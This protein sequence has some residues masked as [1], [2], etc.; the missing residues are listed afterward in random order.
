M[1]YKI[2]I[3]LLCA[4]SINAS[5]I[6]NSIVP[7]LEKFEFPQNLPAKKYSNNQY[8]DIRQALNRKEERI[9]IVSYQI[10]Y[11]NEKAYQSWQWRV[12]RL[13]QI[14]LN[15]NP[16]IFCLQ[17]INNDQLRNLSLLFQD[18]HYFG[19]VGNVNEINAIFV[20]KERF[21]MQ[22]QE[23]CPLQGRIKATFIQL[24]D[25]K[26]QHSFAVIN[27]RLTYDQPD[28]REKEI[29]A[30]NEFIAPI[31]EKMP[32][33]LAG[34]F[35]TYAPRLD[36]DYIPFHDGNYIQR[37]LNKSSLKNSLKKAVLGHMGPL[38]STISS[39]GTPYVY[40]DQIFVSENIDVLLH[41]VEPATVDGFY[42]SD[43]MPVI[44][45]LILNEEMQ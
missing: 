28:Q 7:K 12:N 18:Y 43:H 11:K 22:Q 21:T 23:I 34:A 26:T 3:F 20:R 33:I 9:R 29:L 5:E 8:M 40:L 17:A 24:L 38:T 35:H 27:T 42:P 1:I 15:S 19:D 10:F 6:E 41:A 36:L 16:D 45:D 14:I 25:Q 2:A 39:K 4:L 44:V 37:L 31:R 32:V 30:L 13:A